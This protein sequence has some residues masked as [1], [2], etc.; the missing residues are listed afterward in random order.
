LYKL[1]SKGTLD[2]SEIQPY[3]VFDLSRPVE[4]PAGEILEAEPLEAE[5]PALDALGPLMFL[6]GAQ[7]KAAH[8]LVEARREAETVKQDVYNEAKLRGEEEGKQEIL[9]AL[10]SFAQ[11]AQSLIVF[12]ERM[13]TRFTPDI[14]RLA[15]EIA[16]KVVGK[17]VVEDHEIVASVLERAKREVSDAK[18]IRI[19]LHPLDQEILAEMRPALVRVGE[20]GGRKIE[21]L[22]SED[23]G[24]GGCRIETEIGVV[25][26]TI[27]TQ[28]EEIQRQ[29][30]DE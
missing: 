14:V 22:I 8:I 29:L 3:Q 10:V 30:L 17:A 23:I 16:A 21:V 6:T 1:V 28:L 9:P 26:A 27:P 2:A 13:V 4:E 20:E 15:L 24:R 12:E 25:D 11:A 19:R 5:P 18:L 7:E